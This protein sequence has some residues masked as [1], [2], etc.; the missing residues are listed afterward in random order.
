[1]EAM[2]CAAVLGYLGLGL[3]LGIAIAAVTVVIIQAL[4]RW[5][6]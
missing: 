3:V 6:P 2:S 5:F 4:L 1:M